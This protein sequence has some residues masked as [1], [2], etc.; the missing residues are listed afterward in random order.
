M[1]LFKIS[2]L[3]GSSLDD[4][5]FLVLRSKWE[6]YA[7]D[8]TTE[9]LIV[10]R[11]QG[12]MHVVAQGNWLPSDLWMSP[13]GNL[14]FVGPLGG[15][16]GLYRG[17]PDDESYRW[18]RIPEVTPKEESITR[19]EGVWG[20][21]DDYVFCWGGGWLA[22]E[23][24]RAH[25]N[26]AFTWFC[27]GRSWRERPSAGV[28]LS[29]HGMDRDSIFTVGNDGMV[30]RWHGAEWEQMQRPARSAAIGYVHVVSADEAY[31]AS[32]EGDLFEGSQHGWH[33]LG[34]ADGFVNGL[35]KWNGD[36]LVAMRH[37]FGR[38]E[39][40]R[41][42]PFKDHLDSYV[43]HAGQTLMWTDG[44][45]ILET[46]DFSSFVR[47]HHGEIGALVNAEHFPY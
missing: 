34:S 37:G 29:V 15:R 32:V 25:L 41:V 33:R 30:A 16:R 3:T 9:W 19:P 36:V 31:A 13:A 6:D 8:D 47:L 14:Y 2:V 38:L 44:G 1:H 18:T 26:R 27:D 35:V 39:M 23:P 20:L 10:R 45:G 22:D 7:D 4:C 40:N 12:H 28:M 43:F 5:A 17:V 42:V 46:A 24:E 21:S 11:R